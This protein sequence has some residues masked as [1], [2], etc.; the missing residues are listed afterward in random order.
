MACVGL[1]SASSA[2]LLVDT[3]LNSGCIDQVGQATTIYHWAFEDGTEGGPAAFAHVESS[4][5]P[6]EEEV[7]KAG[8][9]L[10]DTCSAHPTQ[11][12]SIRESQKHSHR[13]CRNACHAWYT[14]LGLGSPP[15]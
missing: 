7:Q 15:G 10:S 1:S 11:L 4:E 8:L 3:P 5:R 14:A 6:S 13:I 12:A 2:T 9:P